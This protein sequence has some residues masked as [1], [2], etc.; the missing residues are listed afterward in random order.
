MK[1]NMQNVYPLIEN[2]QINYARAY[3][4]LSGLFIA[5]EMGTYT[6]EEAIEHYNEIWHIINNQEERESISLN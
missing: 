3:G 5:L 1:D 4:V 6:K 2:G